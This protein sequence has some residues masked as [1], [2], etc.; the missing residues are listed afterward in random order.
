[1]ALLNGIG[2][3]FRQGAQVRPED[4]GGTDQL[5]GQGG[6]GVRGVVGDVWGAVK[7]VCPTRRQM[8]GAVVVSLAVAGG[9]ALIVNRANPDCSS[10]EPL[11]KYDSQVTTAAPECIQPSA[12]GMGVAAGM[13]TLAIS[14]GGAMV[15]NCET[16]AK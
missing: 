12:F 6:R 10:N 9:A 4:G 5:Q 13:G 1:M 15:F 16:V 11:E 8:A 14:T 2:V 7:G 3:I